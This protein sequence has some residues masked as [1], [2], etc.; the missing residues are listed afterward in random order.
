VDDEPPICRFIE[1]GLR[2][3][4]FNNLIFSSNGSNV[5]NR[6]LSERPDLII[7]DV[8][9]PGGNGLKALRILRSAPVTARIPVIITSGF[10]VL[11]VGDCE[12]SRP[13][14]VLAKPFTVE[15]LLKAV[16]SVLP[17]TGHTQAVTTFPDLKAVPA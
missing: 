9:M 14:R 10:S 7:M 3:A 6:A 13:D 5:P 17:A 1:Q 11:T 16:G 15:Q 8:M 2:A 12:Q 4:G